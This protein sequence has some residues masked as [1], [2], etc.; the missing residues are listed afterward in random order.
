MPHRKIVSKK[1]GK[2]LSSISHHARI[3]I[4]AELHNN[5]RCVSELKD[6]LSISSSSVS[7]HLSVLKAINVVRERRDGHHV[8]YSL[9]N[10]RIALW[11]IEAVSFIEPDLSVNKELTQAIRKTQ[12][13]WLSREKAASPS[14]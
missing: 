4:I 3:R 12:S 8:F 10:P 9:T 11:L 14:K 13:N 6:L 1:L 2:M 7:H 5:E